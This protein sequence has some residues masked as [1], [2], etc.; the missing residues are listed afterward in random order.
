M[1]E[2]AKAGKSRKRSILATLIAFAVITTSFAFL[3]YPGPTETQL[4]LGPS[5]NASYERN[6][7]SE[8][9]ESSPTPI[10]PMIGGNAR[11][12]GLSPYD[13]SENKGGL[14]WDFPTNGSATSVSIGGDGT[15]YFGDAKYLYAVYPNGTLRWKYEAQGWIPTTPAIDNDG[16][17]YFGTFEFHSALDPQ[18]SFV[19]ACLYSVLPNGTLNWRY[20][21]SGVIFSSP[22]IGEDGAIYVGSAGNLVD[23]NGGLF[24]LN[25]D[26]TLRWSLYTGAGVYSSPAIGSDGTIYVTNVENTVFAVRPDGTTKWRHMLGDITSITYDVPNP[27]PFEGTSTRYV[28]KSKIEILSSPVIA[29]DGTIYFGPADWFSSSFPVYPGYHH[30]DRDHN[31]YALNPDGTLKWKFPTA[32]FVVSS[33]AIG[34]DG[35]IYA[36][37]F[38]DLYDAQNQNPGDATGSRQYLYAINPDGHMRWRYPTKGFLS[39]SPTV[40]ANGIIYF[41]ADI[42]LNAVNPDSTSRWSFTNNIEQWPS[43]A[44]VIGP[45]G[46][47]Y[48]GFSGG[49]INLKG[50]LYALDKGKPS[51]PENV[52]LK[53]GNK[54][55]ISWSLPKTDG[56][57]P[58][59][60]YKIY[61]GITRLGDPSWEEPAVYFATVSGSSLSFTDTDVNKEPAVKYWYYVTAVNDYGEGPGS[62]RT[63]A[64]YYDFMNVVVIIALVVAPILVTTA[65]LYLAFRKRR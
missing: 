1:I 5:V 59:T 26:G 11:H 3:L 31:L 35:T 23:N 24:V 38:E 30:P 51:S 4:I 37:S 53:E 8:R 52:V 19:G 27:P 46:T 2:L 58:I 40:D 45:S 34:S 28:F 18:D 14:K 39:S 6:P 42:R 36:V 57:S 16:V 47:V 25:S 54:N 33:P 10:W 63:F 49:Y 7:G 29:P 61:R 21:T 20:N 55:R 15:L 12:T 44:P 60:E 64:A 62:A 50:G 22:V 65:A 32:G 41:Y 43:A 13:T 9:L 48:F 56:G 17:V